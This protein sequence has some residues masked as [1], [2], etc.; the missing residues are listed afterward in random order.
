MNFCTYV[1]SA[2]EIEECA[3]IPSIREV[4]LEPASLALQGKLS[5][6]MAQDLATLAQTHGLSPIL[7]WDIEL[8]ERLFQKSCDVLHQIDLSLFDGIRVRDLGAA[9]Y[10]A[11][12]HPSVPLQL[13]LEFSNH[14]T[15]SIRRWEKAFSNLSRI[16]LSPELSEEKLTEICKAVTTPC[17]VLGAGPVLLFRSPRPLL[18]SVYKEDGTQELPEQIEVLSS[19]EESSHREFPTIENTH[20]TSM[21]LHKDLFLLDKL[22]NLE[23]CG[24]HTVRLDL[25]NFLL[26][27][28]GGGENDL[29]LSSICALALSDPAALKKAW[30]RKTI[31]PF[32]R[33]NKTTAQFHRLKSHLCQLRD[34]KCVATVL[35][36]KKGNAVLFAYQDFS[37]DTSLVLHVPKGEA[38]GVPPLTCRSL[39]GQP[40]KTVPAG[41]VF[42]A[43]P[44]T[45]ARNGALLRKES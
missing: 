11:T 34:E 4:L 12:H 5:L 14:N 10:L 30:P 42:L 21:F 33:I 9:R 40:L 41:T 18:S 44:L 39:H 23:S 25:R 22:E 27:Q 36:H 8:P 37:C 31:A 45:R 1:R 24:I 6:Q 19:S 28:D 16:I 15:R 26:F 2:E 7:I 32:F 43:S 35:S 17:E 29:S 3:K 38:T 20:G 13:E